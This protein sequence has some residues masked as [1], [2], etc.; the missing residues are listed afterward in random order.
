[1]QKLRNCLAKMEHR[2]AGICRDCGL[3]CNGVL[4]ETVRLQAGD[5]PDLLTSL[6]LK[7]KRKA[8]HRCF[9][10]PCPAWEPEGCRIYEDRPARCRAFEC[11]QIAKFRAG[12][13][14]EADVR[15]KIEET[16]L[17]VDSLRQLLRECGSRN[18]HRSLI[19]RCQMVLSDEP[20]EQT[21]PK[22][23]QLR[24]ELKELEQE[25]DAEFRIP[26]N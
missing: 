23:L 4:F 1:M 5:S 13:I 11:R 7:L 8:G 15:R 24:E 6:G 10:Q 26:S 20:T 9:L 2:I 3:C 17:L 12:E 22:L 25:L 14:D 19:K 16:K 21:A 18:E